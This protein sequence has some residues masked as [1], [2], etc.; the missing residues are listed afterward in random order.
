MYGIDYRARA[1]DPQLL[2]ARRDRVAIAARALD[3]A[4]M[5]RYTV[6]VGTLSSTE[7]VRPASLAPSRCTA[8]SAFCYASSVH[9]TSFGCGLVT[10]TWALR[11][12]HTQG[13]VASH[14]YIKHSSVVVFNEWFTKKPIM[15]C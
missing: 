1:D 12:T 10:C 6:D 5:L 15:V 2:V 13:R 8:H 9:N 7:L 11:A 4:R 14:Y 3:D